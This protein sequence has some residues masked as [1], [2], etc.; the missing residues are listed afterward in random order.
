M[1][2]SRPRAPKRIE[3]ELMQAKKL[4]WHNWLVIG[5]DEENH[6]VIVH[7]T[8]GRTKRLNPTKKV[9]VSKNKKSAV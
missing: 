1:K 9:Y 3:K 8:S 5:W 2:N 6:L 7:K 4:D